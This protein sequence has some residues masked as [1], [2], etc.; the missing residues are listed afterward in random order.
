MEPP[1]KPVLYQY[2]ISPFCD[3]VRRAMRLKGIEWDIVEVPVVPPGKFKHISP[4]GKFP[5]VDFGGG[6]IVVDS[7]DIIRHLDE[8]APE[9]RLIPI[10]PRDRADALILE[11][12]AD[13]SLYFFDLTMRNWPQNR[14]WFVDDLLHIETGLKRRFLAA[15]VPGALRKVA[16][17]Q[18]LGRKTEAQVVAE[19]TRHYDGLEAKLEGRQ[20]LVGDTI[21]IA[22]L[23]VR[24]MLFVL[25]RTIEA[26]ALREAR[27]ALTAWSARVDAASL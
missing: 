5:A 26:K 9:P 8:I 19:L 21:S 3:K 2:R 11:D 1:V 6:K 12:W 27:P 7:T 15:M 18:G 20:W 24:S 22:D 23:A 10:D 14:Q 25:D 16:V 4:T 17:T 13:E